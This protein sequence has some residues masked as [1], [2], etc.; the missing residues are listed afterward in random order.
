MPIPPEIQRIIDQIN[1][2]LNEIERDANQGIEIVNRLLSQFPGN[3]YL[4]RAFT[5]FGNQIFFIE[6]TKRRIRF[7]LENLSIEDVSEDIIQENG[8]YLSE[9]SGQVLDYKQEVNSLK[10]QLEDLL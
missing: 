7:C 6:M 1:R 3:D 5:R 2:D 10:N 4:S 9:I 8:E